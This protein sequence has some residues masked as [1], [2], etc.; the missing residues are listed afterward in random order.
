M[1]NTGSSS[2]W[3]LKRFIS[4]VSSSC[5]NVQIVESPYFVVLCSKYRMYGKRISAISKCGLYFIAFN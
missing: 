4:L 1:F 3:L 2:E 5:L